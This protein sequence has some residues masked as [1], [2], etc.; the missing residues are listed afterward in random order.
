MKQK[1][2]IIIMSLII[3]ILAIALFIC[4]N[5]NIGK[6]KIENPNPLSEIT[7]PEYHPN[8]YTS[9]ELQRFT[10]ILVSK[11]DDSTNLN[12]YILYTFDEYDKCISVRLSYEYQT[13]EESQ[14]EF[15]KKSQDLRPELNENIL[16][17]S[18]TDMDITKQDIIENMNDTNNYTFF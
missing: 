11:K 6:I 7:N 15:E 1:V 10:H 16:T 17:F 12:N 8:P 14:K 5:K 4:N 3:V 2:I 18:A 13:P 9:D